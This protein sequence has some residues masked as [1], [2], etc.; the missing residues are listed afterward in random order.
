MFNRRIGIVHY[1]SYWMNNKQLINNINQILTIS[2]QT[3][4]N[5]T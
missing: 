4:S 2:D 1:H 5:N 3:I